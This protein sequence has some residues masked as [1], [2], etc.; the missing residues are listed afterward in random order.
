MVLKL[1]EKIYRYYKPN[2]LFYDVVSYSEAFEVLDIKAPEVVKH[3]DVQEL[4]QEDIEE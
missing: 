3:Y 1:F 2:I 4:M